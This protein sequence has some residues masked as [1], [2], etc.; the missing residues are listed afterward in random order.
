MDKDA[1][2]EWII[3]RSFSDLSDGAKREATTDINEQLASIGYRT[4][5]WEETMK[6]YLSSREIPQSEWPTGA[7]ADK[8]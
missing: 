3:A 6:E 1:F 7:L 4:N 8:E 5:S 2:I